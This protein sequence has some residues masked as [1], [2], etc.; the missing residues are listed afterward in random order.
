VK[1]KEALVFAY[2]GLL[3]WI[4]QPNTLKEIT[5]ASRNGYGGCIYWA[6]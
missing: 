6:D 5:G 3:R 1:Y 4:K 2:L